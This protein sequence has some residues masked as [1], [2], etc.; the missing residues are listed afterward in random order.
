MMHAETYISFLVAILG[1]AYP[2]IIQVVSRLEDKYNSKAVIIL[3]EKE[4]TH[5]C[6]VG[7]LIISIVATI[8]WT[9]DLPPIRIAI[10]ETAMNNSA[11]WFVMIS[12]I[13]LLI[14]FL[15]EMKLLLTYSLAMRLSD[16]FIRHYDRNV[17]NK[18]MNF[19]ALGDLLMNAIRTNDPERANKLFD[20]VEGEFDAYRKQSKEYPPP[21]YE[22]SKKLL[23]DLITSRNTAVR[24]FR[25]RIATASLLLRQDLINTDSN[26]TL[27]H[28]WGNLVLM[29]ES[30][31]IDMFMLYWASMDGRLRDYRFQKL[32]E[33]N[34]TPEPWESMDDMENIDVGQDEETTEK[35]DLIDNRMKLYHCALGGL[36]V[37][38]QKHVALKRMFL[39]TSSEPQKFHLLPNTLKDVYELFVFFMDPWGDNFNFISFTYYFPHIEG[40]N[41][42]SMIKNWICSYIAILFLRLYKLGPQNYGQDILEIKELPQ[43]QRDKRIWL[44]GIES[45]RIHVNEVLRQLDMLENIGL[46]NVPQFWQSTPTKEPDAVINKIKDGLIKAMISSEIGQ[47][48]STDKVSLFYN[49]SRSMFNEYIDSLK[50][51]TSISPK[52]ADCNKTYAYGDRIILEKSCFHADQVLSPDNYDSILASMVISKLKWSLSHSFVINTSDRYQ[53]KPEDIFPAIDKLKLNKDTHI[54]INMN[55]NL[56]YYIDVLKVKDL[57]VRDY[58]G[59]Q[60]ESLDGYD[61]IAGYSVL[62]IEKE[63]LPFLNYMNLPEE[64]VTKFH[65]TEHIRDNKILASVINLKDD[66]T[67]RLELQ[68]LNPDKDL[69]RYVLVSIDLALEI[70]WDKDI[71]MVQIQQYLHRDSQQLLSNLSDVKRF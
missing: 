71:Q 65:L 53:L 9:L 52:N 50:S 12:I 60:I 21:Y 17:S 11:T 43:T 24:Q 54:I 39:Y 69:L 1:I 55:L 64:A 8:L 44:E 45:F 25:F 63:N 66:E 16:R 22:L 28:I 40:V 62:I 23:E 37:Y 7:L 18:F 5:R 51:A 48:L 41:Q 32:Y 58:N 3:F 13:L 4:R 47:A 68:P 34:M 10:I 2:I 6:Y 57:T 67:L 29:L 19:T 14:T 59:I 27:T 42:D 33:N 15:F 36:V 26:N 20:L 30:D 49:S 35:P 56:S 38:L 31:S 61:R 46:G 70:Q